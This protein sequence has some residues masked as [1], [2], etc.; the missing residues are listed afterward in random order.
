MLIL[1]ILAV[2]Y[3]HIFKDIIFDTISFLGN[4]I[5]GQGTSHKRQQ[6]TDHFIP[7]PQVFSFGSAL[8]LSLHIF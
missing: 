4:A 3:C 2:K 6:K 7:L 1:L 5:F 8:K